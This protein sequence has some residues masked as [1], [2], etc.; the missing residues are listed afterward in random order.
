MIVGIYKLMDEGCIFTT[1]DL[2]CA[3]KVTFDYK[4]SENLCGCNSSEL[5]LATKKVLL[6]FFLQCSFQWLYFFFLFLHINKSFFML[7]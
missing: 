5:N 2:F 7:I 4:Q 3:Q 1:D 6:I